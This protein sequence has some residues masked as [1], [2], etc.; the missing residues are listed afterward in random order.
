[1]IEESWPWKWIFLRLSHLSCLPVYRMDSRSSNGNIFRITGP[2]WANSPVTGEFPSQRPVTRNFDVFFLSAPGKWLCKQSRRRWFDILSRLLWCHCNV[3]NLTFAFELLV[4]SL[5][6]SF[7]GRN[8][9][10]VFCCN[11]WRIG[12]SPWSRFHGRLIATT[13]VMS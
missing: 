12:E 6:N 2:L 5:R 7:S 10:Q 3:L 9:D 13:G 8:T 4:L 11:G 1:M